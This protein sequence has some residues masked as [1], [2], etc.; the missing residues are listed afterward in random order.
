MYKWIVDQK[1]IGGK[2]LGWP[3]IQILSYNSLL[4]YNSLSAA[5]HLYMN[6]ALVMMMLR[7]IFFSDQPLDEHDSCVLYWIVCVFFYN[8]A[9]SSL[10]MPTKFFFLW[11][12]TVQNFCMATFK[13]VETFITHCPPICSKFAMLLGSA[14]TK[15][16]HIHNIYFFSLQI[17]MITF[18]KCKDSS[19]IFTPCKLQYY[20]LYY[21]LERHFERIKRKENFNL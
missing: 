17:I 16:T 14:K 15:H 6:L 7:V 13:N 12:K 21:N 2:K 19:K 11:K 9:H 10:A 3:A 1:W 5:I 8:A 20:A 18:W 4:V